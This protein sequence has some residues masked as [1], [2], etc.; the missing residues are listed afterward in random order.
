VKIEAVEGV[1]LPTFAFGNNQFFFLL[2]LVVRLKFEANLSYRKEWKADVVH[3]APLHSMCCR[4][5]NEA[6]EGVRLA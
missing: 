5:G 6:F 4:Y 2:F 1:Q 3:G